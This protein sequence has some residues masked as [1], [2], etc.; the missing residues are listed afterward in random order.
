M[1]CQT[2]RANPAHEPKI[3]E[4]G[5]LP[6][7]NLSHPGRRGIHIEVMPYRWLD[8]SRPTVV[9]FD[10][11]SYPVFNL[12]PDQG[13]V[14]H[15]RISADAAERNGY[16]VIRVAELSAGPLLHLEL[17]LP[18]LIAFIEDGTVPIGRGDV[19][20]ISAVKSVPFT[21]AGKLLK[22]QLTPENLKEMVPLILERLAELQC[23]VKQPRAVREFARRQV[24][25]NQAVA[26]LCAAQHQIEVVAA[27]G[28]DGPGWFNIALMTA[29]IQLSARDASG[30]IAPWSANN[31]LTTPAD[32]DFEILME[33][34]S[35]L[36]AARGVSL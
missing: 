31:S 6:Q 25:S 2:K 5:P 11:F 30:E 4:F 7:V 13:I 27:G 36:I 18:E 21:G 16:N 34:A 24:E 29:T 33:P 35:S 28:N 32:G 19:V 1:S 14:S 26:R 3:V 12:P 9:V 15:G 10:K 22:L 8:H 17:A 20:N 23:D